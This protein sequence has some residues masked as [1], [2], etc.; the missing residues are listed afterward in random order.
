MRD[1]AVAA[2]A[3]AVFTVAHAQDKPAAA[4]PPS[5]HQ[6]KPPALG[7]STL[8]PFAPNL[9]G[10]SAKDLPTDKLKVP[11]GFKVKSG[12]KAFPRR[13]RSRAAKRA[14]CS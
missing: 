3:M 2:A 6:G 11:P 9:A 5:W 12:P 10:R 7:E 8:H 13:A 1:L 14:R 4:P